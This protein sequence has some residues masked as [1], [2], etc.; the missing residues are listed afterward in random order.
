MGTIK[1]WRDIR[2][3]P[4]GKV[5]RVRNWWFLGIVR[6]YNRRLSFLARLMVTLCRFV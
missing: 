1:C 5:I 6:T 2:R 3:G 4:D